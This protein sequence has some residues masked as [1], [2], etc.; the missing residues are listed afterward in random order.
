MICGLPNTEL[1]DFHIC[2]EILDLAGR[3]MFFGRN[4]SGQ[5]QALSLAE[6]IGDQ[7]PDIHFVW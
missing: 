3:V 7:G 1:S 2:H 6:N 4:E 5:C